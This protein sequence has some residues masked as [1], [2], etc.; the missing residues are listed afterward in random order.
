MPVNHSARLEKVENIIR[1]INRMA[2]STEGISINDIMV[3]Y[4]VC[5]RTAERMMNIIRALYPAQLEEVN[6]GENYKS[7]RLQELY[8]QGPIKLAPEEI[9]CL[10]Q[11]IKLAHRGKREELADELQHLE[12]RIK[13]FCK[14]KDKYNVENIA[15]MEDI[16]MSAGPKYIINQEILAGLRN[17]ITN[18]NEVIITYKLRANGETKHF[19]IQ[20]YGI[21]YGSRPYLVAYYETDKDYRY[22]C[23]S[24]IIA[25]ELT[26]IKF[27]RNEK[28][29][30]QK[31][32]EQSFGSFQEKP[33]NVIWKVNKN[34][35]DDAEH[36][37]FHPTQTIEKQKDGSL[38]VRFTAG[39][40]KEMCW[41]LFTWEG[42]IMIL[43]PQVLKETMCD[44]LNKA[45]NML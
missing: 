43:E 15:E 16:S 25:I 41:H 21:L 27:S 13:S 28:F 7:Y 9:S 29:S 19:R 42:D 17:A 40:L 32:A 2:G 35:A 14:E 8:R 30:L 26:D 18:W 37:L 11:A 10:S 4:K 33:Y 1:L 34:R 5:R 45:K 20:P 31:Y 38:I 3:E 6:N 36:Y 39:G 44:L 22:F 24:N 23:L 12:Y